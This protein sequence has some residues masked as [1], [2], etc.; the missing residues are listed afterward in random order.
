MIE[1][2]MIEKHMYIYKHTND[3]CTHT[4]KVVHRNKIEWDN[5]N[6]LIFKS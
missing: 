4:H 5:N 6:G 2:E 1:V 3:I